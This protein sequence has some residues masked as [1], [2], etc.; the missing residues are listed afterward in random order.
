MTRARSSRGGYAIAE[1]LG[2]GAALLLVL[3]VFVGTAYALGAALGVVGTGASGLSLARLERVL[4]ARDTWAGL[5]FTLWVG[6]A[7]T[8]LATAGAV[9]FAVLFRGS[10]RADLG[11]LIAET[12]E[13]VRI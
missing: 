12:P 9:V 4:K 6:A 3:P 8:L 13:Y 11:R 10:S 7:S 1:A 2:L 5:G